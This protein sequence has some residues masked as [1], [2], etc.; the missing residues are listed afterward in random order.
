MAGSRV[1][2][3]LN[4]ANIRK[5]DKAV[6]KSIEQTGEAVHTKLISKAYMPFDTGHMQNVN[7]FVNYK[8]SNKGKVSII[9]QAPQARRLYFHPEY[10]FQTVNNKNA[11]GMW[12]EPFKS[13]KDKDFVMTAFKKFIKINGGF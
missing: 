1:T 8:N 6:I 10:N 2:I 5:I 4:K 13:G 12:F 9:T 7:T 11:G 3:K